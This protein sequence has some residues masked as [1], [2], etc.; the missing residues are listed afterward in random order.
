MSPGKTM[1]R[2][3]STQAERAYHIIKQAILRADIE[4]GRF[5]SEEELGNR[6]DISRTPF[7]EACNRLHDEKILEVVPRRG[8]FVPEL[9]FRGFGD[10]FEVRLVIEGSIAEIAA[11]RATPEQIAELEKLAHGFSSSIVSSAEADQTIKLNTEF[12]L[13]LA[14]MTQNR[15]LV[16][17]QRKM[18]ERTERLMYIEYRRCGFPKPLVSKL[19]KPVLDA[20]RKRD[21]AG[22]RRA[23]CND[24]MQSQLRTAVLGFPTNGLGSEHL[25][26][27]NA[28]DNSTENPRNSEPRPSPAKS[29]H[30][31]TKE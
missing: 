30:H 22:A 18:L 28:T 3:K 21:A 15:E 17:L 13:C 6:Y 9:S 11:E 20:I 12:H 25:E 24:I 10:L 2:E 29:R 8:Y 31:N 16:E 27:P 14:R 5:L 1:R 7:R 4:E 26:L 19:H 23:I